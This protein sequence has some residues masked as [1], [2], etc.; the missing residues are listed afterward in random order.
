MILALGKRNILEDFEN[1][2]PYF[3]HFLQTV[4][5]VEKSLTGFNVQPSIGM[6]ESLI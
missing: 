3:A 5:A 6:N 4:Y 1:V 2:S